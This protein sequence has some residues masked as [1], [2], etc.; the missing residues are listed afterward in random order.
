MVLPECR[1]LW[2]G[3]ERADSLAFNP[4]KWRT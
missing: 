2:A 4:H 3:V 1:A